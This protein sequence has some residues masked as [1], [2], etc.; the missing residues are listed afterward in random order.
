MMH[1]HPFSFRALP[2]MASAATLAAT[3]TLACAPGETTSS[4]AMVLRDSIGDTLIV[5]TVA[6]NGWGGEATLV[7]EMSVGVLDGPSEQIFG[8]I[9]SLAVAADGTLF[10]M[11]GQVPAVRVFGADGVYRTTLGRS[12]EGPGEFGQPDGGMVVL[13]DGRL[14]VRDPGNA[15]MQVF[16]V[17]G[18]PVATWSVIAGG[19][20][21]GRPMIRTQGDT[22]ATPVLVDRE[23]DVTEWTM[24]LQRVAPSGE[25]VD[26]LA[27][28]DA[29]YEAPMLEARREM[30]GG[31]SVSVTG[32]P[33][34]PDEVA[35]LHP[36]GYF[37]HGVSD[38]YAFTLLRPGDWLRIEREVEPARVGRGEGAEAEASTSRSM[39]STDPNWRWNGPAIPDR[40]PYYENIYP[41]EDG[42]IWVLVELEGVERDD[43]NYDPTD[44]ESIEDRWHARYAFDVFDDHGQFMGRVPIPDEVRTY[45]TPV[46]RGDEVWAVTADELDVQRVVRFRLQLPDTR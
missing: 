1:R 2:L 34:A 42:R 37:I 4:M 13:S 23:V 17:D 27:I 19:F 35:R 12:G 21:T 22:I 14:V 16:G 5:R 41:A 3:L 40:K 38:R 29:G 46:I 36:D 11:D 8:S 18:E 30:D 32:V 43:P 45:P 26:T 10:V 9:R 20:Q 25:I 7:P 28:P 31:S 24:G 44:P 39:R 15:R 33:F 6:G